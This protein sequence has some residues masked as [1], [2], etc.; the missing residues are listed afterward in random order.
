MCNVA[1]VICRSYLKSHNVP[2][3]ELYFH[4]YQDYVNHAAV[5][6]FMH[7]SKHVIGFSKHK[8]TNTICKVIRAICFKSNLLKKDTCSV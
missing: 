4:T 5:G 3:G 6:W 1:G 8:K 7:I 2:S